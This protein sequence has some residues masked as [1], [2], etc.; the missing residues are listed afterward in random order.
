M[1]PRS[2]F[3]PRTAAAL[4]AV[5]SSALQVVSAGSP[6][7][8]TEGNI[9][10]TT[11]SPDCGLQ[12]GYRQSVWRELRYWFLGIVTAGISC[13]V[14]ST[15]LPKL[16]AAFRFE[17]CDLACADFVL[18]VSEFHCDM[19]RVESIHHAAS[20]SVSAPQQSV[21]S[22]PW[23]WPWS[24]HSSPVLGSTVALSDRII[25]YRY[26]RLVWSERYLM[27]APIDCIGAMSPHML[28]VLMQRGLSSEVWGVLRRCSIL[29]SMFVC[30]RPCIDQC[31]HAR[32]TKRR[33]KG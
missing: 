25:V 27:F 10:E 26:M 2:P 7:A 3:S 11:P 23:P 12:L 5:P 16:G 30:C 29:R 33:H 13:L 24:S 19:V 20:S 6:L 17:T 28:T 15:W 22:W 21:W 1:L 14:L 8:P 9:T 4:E 32:D 31:N 18:I